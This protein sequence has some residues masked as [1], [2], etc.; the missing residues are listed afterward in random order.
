[1]HVRFSSAA[2]LPVVEEGSTEPVARIDDVVLQPESGKIE[3]FS[4][5]VTRF[6][7]S[8]H[9]ILLPMDI[10]HWGMRVTIRSAHVLVSAEE[11]IR[12][13]SLLQDGRNI[14]GQRMVTERGKHLG[15]CADVQF[16]TAH[17]SIEWLFPRRWWRWGIPVPITDVVEVRT[18]AII[19][20]ERAAKEKAGAVPDASLILGVMP[21]A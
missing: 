5:A 9:L 10:L 16:D 8:D 13:Q 3:A 20:R 21:E 19:V 7:G 11:I 4:V 18:D 12:L 17:F 6:L 2:G 1:M 15:R 14:L